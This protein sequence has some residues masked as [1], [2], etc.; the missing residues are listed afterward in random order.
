MGQRP[1]RDPFGPVEVVVNWLLWLVVG[2][3]LACLAVAALQVATGHSVSVSYATIGDDDSCVV[4]AGGSS[5][6]IVYRSGP[7]YRPS[8]GVYG[9]RH[10]EASASSDTWR[11]CLSDA[12]W[13]QWSAA[14]VEPVGQLAFVV[15]SL[16]L[17]RR[18][19]WVARTAGMFTPETA[20]RTRRLGWFVL[21]WSLTWPFL[22]AAGRGVVIS[23]AVRH[24]SWVRE[25]THPHISLVLV[26]VGV[27]ILTFAR[28]LR[29]AVPLQ[30]EVDATV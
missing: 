17:I 26:V 23:A 21:A 29:L 2:G 12:T 24:Q 30:E 11:I 3:F 8:E 15:V 1:Q 7:G 6:P 19:I 14:R 20:R 13:W 22:A 5:V 25:L 4:A 18:T 28:I 16:L 10:S 9:L 27:G